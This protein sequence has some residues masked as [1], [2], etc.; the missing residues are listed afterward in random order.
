MR[1]MT[2]CGHLDPASMQVW[3]QISQSDCRWSSRRSFLCVPVSKK[4]TQ[5]A[6]VRACVLRGRLSAFPF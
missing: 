6:N 5:K 3:L 4:E 2:M 1:F